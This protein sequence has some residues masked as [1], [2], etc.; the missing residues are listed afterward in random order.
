MSRTQKLAFLKVKNKQKKKQKKTMLISK[1]LN[2]NSPFQNHE[3][4]QLDKSIN[5]DTRKQN[6][7]RESEIFQ[8]LK[9]DKNNTVISQQ[10]IIRVFGLLSSSLLLFP[11]HFG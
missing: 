7:Q 1:E 3:S 4:D 10:L 11:Q 9:P 2:Y 5:I 8:N 6:L